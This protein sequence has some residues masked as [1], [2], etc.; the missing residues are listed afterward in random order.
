MDMGLRF[1]FLRVEWFQTFISES[2]HALDSWCHERFGEEQAYS[3]AWQLF[4][5]FSL[6]TTTVG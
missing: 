2:K 6:S 4:R 1:R 3:I 5:G